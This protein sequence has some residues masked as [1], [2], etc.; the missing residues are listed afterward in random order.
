[1]APTAHTNTFSFFDDVKVEASTLQP[2]DQ[3][4]HWSGTGGLWTVDAILKDGRI[5]VHSDLG[6]TRYFTTEYIDA[7]GARLFLRGADR[8]ISK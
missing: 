6:Q 7:K 8:P 1:M 3:F 5:K 4:H 2:R